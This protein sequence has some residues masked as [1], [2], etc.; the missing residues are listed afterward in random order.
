MAGLLGKTFGQGRAPSWAPTGEVETPYQRASQQWDERLGSART[1]AKNWRLCALGALLVLSG[2]LGLNWYQ[3][4]RKDPLLVRYVEFNPDATVRAVVTPQ[5]VYQPTKAAM[6]ERVR[7]FVILSRGL[8]INPVTVRQQWLEELYKWVTPRG[9]TLLN[10]FARERNPFDQ[11]GKVFISV[12]V[13][14][15]LPL[16]DTTFDVRWIETTYEIRGP[17]KGAQAFSGIYGVEVK[18]PKTEKE[19]QDNAL[20]IFIDTLAVS[21]ARGQSQ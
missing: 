6:A 13:Q 18:V 5:I 12:D 20:G 4:A 19:L 21:T 2:S 15:V 7:K 8:D 1:Q 10:E 11:V 9:A 17:K 3:A 16:S 14:R